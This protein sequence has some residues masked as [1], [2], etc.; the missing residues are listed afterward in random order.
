M[1]AVADHEAAVRARSAP[2]FDWADPFLLA[3]QLDE[4]E[5][6]IQE[7]AFDYCQNA[8]MPRVL[9]ANRHEV[10]HQEIMPSWASSAFS[11]AP[12]PKPMAGRMR[13]TSP[14]G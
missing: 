4:S 8:L 1:T 14:T 3:D 7:A 9:E 10:F 5:R 13:P 2:A 12:C 6:L 11:A